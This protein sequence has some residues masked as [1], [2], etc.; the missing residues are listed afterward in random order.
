MSRLRFD[1][2]HTDTTGCVSAQVQVM[3]P[4]A[5]ISWETWLAVRQAHHKCSFVCLKTCYP[6]LW[7]AVFASFP[8]NVFPNFILGLILEEKAIANAVNIATML[9]HLTQRSAAFLQSPMLHDTVFDVHTKQ[10]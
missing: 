2:E 7:I 5:A 1:T 9:G 6:M 8:C 4:Q 3:D 10:H